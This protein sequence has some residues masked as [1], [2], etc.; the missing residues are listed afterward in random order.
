M[1]S[2]QN[3]NYS[4]LT[5]ILYLVFSFLGGL[6]FSILALRAKRNNNTVFWWFI[7]A[8]IFIGF[9]GVLSFSL[10][11]TSGPGKDAGWYYLGLSTLF[12]NGIAL[13]ILIVTLFTKSN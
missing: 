10:V 3:K 13:L 4:L 6:T 1:E 9:F 5:A 11:F 7:L 12:A 8:L 2:K